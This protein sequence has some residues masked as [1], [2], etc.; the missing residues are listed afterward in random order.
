[1]VAMTVRNISAETHAALKRRAKRAGR[2]TEAEVRAILD[3]AAA[4]E[5]RLGSALV[6][7][8]RG[9]GDD[10][11]IERDRRPVDVADFE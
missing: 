4:S 2:N 3:A 1:M 11:R 7:I 6:A 9:A 10:L 8:F 5:V